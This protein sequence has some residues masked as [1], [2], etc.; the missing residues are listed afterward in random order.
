MSYIQYLNDQREKNPTYKAYGNARLYEKLYLTDPNMPKDWE[1]MNEKIKNRKSK[2]KKQQDR[3]SPSFV[4]SLLEMSDYGMINEDSWEWVKKSYNDSATG[5]AYQLAT[6]QAKFGLDPEWEANIGEDILSLV[7]GFT[8]PLDLALMFTGGWVGKAGLAA[9]SSSKAVQRLAAKE[10]VRKS[11]GK[12]TTKQA[13]NHVKKVVSNESD[14][15]GIL[16]PK[17][18][19]KAALLS[20]F[21]APVKS[22]MGMQA[23]TLA[24]FEGVKG[25]LTEAVYGGDWKKGVRDGVMHGGMMGGV[26]GFVGGSLNVVNAALHS[27]AVA[28]AYQGTA[29]RA[30]AKITK[31]I[32]KDAAKASTGKVGQVLAEGTAFTI[33]DVYKT[34][35]DDNF[36]LKDLTRNALVNIGMMGLLKAK[37]SLIGEG[38]REALDYVKRITKDQ[39]NK[40]ETDIHIDNI[41]RSLDE[42]KGDAEGVG[43]KVYDKSISIAKK[44]LSKAS[45]K[46]N[47]IDLIDGGVG[48]LSLEEIRKLEKSIDKLESDIKSGKPDEK[49]HWKDYNDHMQTIFAISELLNKSIGMHKKDATIKKSVIKRLENLQE[50]WDGEIIGELRNK[51]K[52]G[53]ERIYSSKEKSTIRQKLTDYI[54]NA[55]KYKSKASIKNFLIDNEGSIKTKYDK[56]GNL[57]DIKIDEKNIRWDL[58]EQKL[59][60]YTPKSKKEIQV[61]K[62][63]YSAKDVEGKNKGLTEG[64]VDT[65]TKKREGGLKYVH[66]T[67]RKDERKTV[68]ERI[69]EL[70]EIIGSKNSLAS[71]V[72]NAAKERKLLEKSK[73][74]NKDSVEGLDANAA[75]QKSKSI[76]LH[77]AEQLGLNK[78]IKRKKPLAEESS[79]DRMNFLNRFT[80]WLATERGKS[81]HE[82]TNKDID[83]WMESEGKGY[84]KT[85]LVSLFET[86]KKNSMLLNPQA[87]T[88]TTPSEIVSLLKP[89]GDT[90]TEGLE[91]AR[92]KHILGKES[93]EYWNFGK[94]FVE[95]VQS[96]TNRIKKYVTDDVGEKL[97]KLFNRQEGGIGAEAFMFKNVD[98]KP[99]T[100]KTLRPLIQMIFGVKNIPVGMAGEHRA[101]RYSFMQWAV[102][103]YGEGSEAAQ[104]LK[105]VLGDKSPN[106][107]KTDL[108]KVYGTKQYHNKHASNAKRW[109]KEYL[110]DIDKGGYE[111]KFDGSTKGKRGAFITYKKGDKGGSG[112]DKGGYNTW[113]I[114]EGL[115]KLREEFKKDD[116]IEVED[117]NGKFHYIKKETVETMIQYMIQT[118]PRINE[119]VP[120]S[121]QVSGYTKLAQEVYDA[122]Y[123]ETQRL[124]KEG[125]KPKPKHKLSPNETAERI[126]SSLQLKELM[127]W[128]KK[129]Y[130]D[131]LF[132]PKK[133]E[134]DLGK[135][136]GQYI[137]GRLTGHYIEIASGRAGKDVLPHEVVEF[138]IPAL[139]TM[140]DKFS[141][142]LIKRA[143]FMFKQKGDSIEKA[144]HR[145]IDKLGEYVA[146]RV[147][148]KTV[149]GK[150]RSWVTAFNS[151]MRQK[152]NITNPNDVERVRQEMIDIIGEKVYKGRIPQNY[153]PRGEALKVKYKKANTELLYKDLLKVHN[154]TRAI[155]KEVVA[156]GV[157]KKNVLKLIKDE[158]GI[159]V[160]LSKGFN[161][162]LWNIKKSDKNSVNASQLWNLQ[163]RINSLTEGRGEGKRKGF[164]I[165][166]EMVVNIEKAKNILPEVRNKIFRDVYGVK[167]KNATTKQIKAYRSYLLVEKD[168]NSTNTSVLS[169]YKPSISFK[170]G[171]KT[172]FM[173][174]GDVLRTHGGKMGETIAERI[175]QHDYVRTRYYAEMKVA[176]DAVIDIINAGSSNKIEAIKVKNNYMHLM[177][178][179]LVSNAVKQLTELSKKDSKYKKELDNV[180]RIA[181]KFGYRYV[182]DKKMR[183]KLVDVKNGDF[184]Q[185]RVDWKQLTDG[186]FDALGV[187]VS[188]HTNARQYHEIM[189]DL[190]GMYI[191]DYF[192]RRVRHQVLEN[193]DTAS[194]DIK[195]LS[196]SIKANLSKKDLK[197][198][199]NKL[200]TDKMIEKGS[201]DY[202]KLLKKDG[203]FLDDFIGNEIYNMFAFGPAKVSPYFLKS[204]G[205]TLPEYIEIKVNG[206]KKLV[207]SY[208]SSIDATMTHYGLG[209]SK[210]LATVRL[211]P[212]WT[213]LGGKFSIET[214]TRASIIKKMESDFGIGT[215]ALK[216]IKRQLGLD[217]DSSSK[218]NAKW[219]RRIGNVVNLSA[220]VGLSSPTSGFKNLI[221]QLPR[222]VYLYGGRN[223]MKAMGR[224]FNTMT[225][226]LLFRE[227]VKEGLTGYGQKTTLLET[228]G[229]LTRG[230]KFWFENV[231]QMERSENFNRIVLAEAG[232]MFFNEMVAQ[233]R[234]EKTMFNVHKLMTEKQIGREHDRYFKEVWRMTDKQVD[235][236]RNGKDVYGSKEYGILMEW[237]G[238]QSHKRGA[239]ATGVGDLPLWMS[240]R[241]VKP[242]TLFQRI[243]MSV[244]NDTYKNVV[245]PLKN[246]NIAPLV[247][248]TIGHAVSGAALY[249]MYKWVFNQQIP[250]EESEYLDK[251]VANI[252]RSEAF[253]VFGEI[254]PAIMKYGFRR[255][256]AGTRDDMQLIM[257]PVIY[258]NVS[259]GWEEVQKWIKG[260]KTKENAVLDWLTQTVVLAGQ[261]EKLFYAF[262]HPYVTENKNLKQLERTFRDKINHP[263][264]SGMVEGNERSPFYWDL[265]QAILTASNDEDIAKAYYAAF[266]YIVDELEDDRGWTSPYLREK[267]ARRLLK[268]TVGN[269]NPLSITAN[270]QG[271][272][273]SLR[274]E[275]LNWL[276]PKNETMA[277]NLEKTF[278]VK[279]RRYESII[280]NPEYR[281]RFSLYTY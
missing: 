33:P 112:K 79:I 170:T 157:S 227:A 231:N 183:M 171:A 13:K 152:L 45:D 212:E 269:M 16:F 59:E 250:H 90:A 264:R 31:K 134:K 281:R 136:D 188:K 211:F 159:E 216:A 60:A 6:G 270:K 73:E 4:N 185:A 146:N 151:Y 78:I 77:Y 230:I 274:N 50:K 105:L 107:I 275:F 158:L 203:K 182:P 115:R 53:K 140:G 176:I 25:G 44:Y 127:Q 85:D 111:I 210:F 209:M 117:K 202:K 104:I 30:A 279:R 156:Q 207:K 144:E 198:I 83:A 280:K 114:K 141:K 12:I 190:N 55:I 10:M 93:T 67:K 69:Q 201:A 43:Q 155:M 241:Y 54:E 204:R 35:T 92:T 19:E 221:I 130:K 184:Y 200:V 122:Q 23:S 172:M 228:P 266:N 248:A 260:T 49:I 41:S 138:A 62:D 139:K 106:D 81:L 113:E 14:G 236:I 255:P 273:I 2:R 162:K 97:V 263:T 94:N 215:Y 218:L 213:N 109:V 247:K 102:E 48:K 119:I 40:I 268:I 82:L 116:I 128:A 118:A 124:I 126:V 11:G 262:K 239:G 235:W 29:E 253:G 34:I 24:V 251:I 181:A 222:T 129:A 249:H 254:I 233:S 224:G 66:E 272:D 259:S 26:A 110:G 145:F 163:S 199:A 232:K 38:K 7:L 226:P 28:K 276:S 169:Y 265:K 42:G 178:K 1:F 234:G 135:F 238:H 167:F 154:Q 160:D 194:R 100:G 220:A 142:D 148:D 180:I 96:K 206:K 70:T 161:Q 246:G 74:I 15:M 256:I 225:D 197:K 244:T 37:H 173:T 17:T 84:H 108:I 46:L 32:G 245:K 164:T 261:G 98:Y 143:T 47:D 189:K 88:Y 192:T 9:S 87:L 27:K 196:N 137:L 61:G 120:T 175:D 65:T 187:E 64:I 217:M 219:Q 91:G 174:V 237:V 39:R 3:N 36:T 267:E 20:Q 101:F 56:K 21:A 86:L 205:V 8:M 242:W 57:K 18:Q 252:W 5:M 58:L 132:F 80:K 63:I 95:Y 257:E 193:W 278:Q 229:K 68:D 153:I 177:D 166:E 223:T 125:K 75:Y 131:K 89:I 52:M 165:N 195:K 258:R 214:G 99:I 76:L 123:A 179:K 186:I 121:K 72:F 277:L 71:E 22:M 103:K 147:L 150:I 168:Y 191:K 208:E 133:W 240:Q 51:G 149:I 243:A 271:R